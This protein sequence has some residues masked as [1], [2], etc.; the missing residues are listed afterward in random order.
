MRQSCG[1]GTERRAFQ[2]YGVIAM[3]PGS[4]PTVIG[5]PAVLVTVLIGITVELVT[6]KAVLPFGVIAMLLS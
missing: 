3:A 6:T 2:L 1:S 5:E 4:L